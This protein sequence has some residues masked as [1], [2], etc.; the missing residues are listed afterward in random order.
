[1]TLDARAPVLLLGGT[2]WVGTQTTKL[3]RQL[4]PTLPIAIA[5]R[6]R[7]KAEALAA[8]WAHTVAV[9]ADVGQ[10]GLGLGPQASYSAVVA[11]LKENTLHP[12]RFAQAHGLPYISMADGAFEIGPAVARHIHRPGS[13]PMM[14]ASHWAAGM[15]TLP[16]LHH[17]SEFRSIESIRAAVIMDPNDPIG[18]MAQVDVQQ[19]MQ[20][21]PRPL[22]LDNGVWR[23]ID[24]RIASRRLKN[25][26][27]NE[28]QVF[29]M[30]V[31][32]T[33]SLAAA[34]DARSVRLDFGT[35]PTSGDGA[36]GACPHELVLE[37][38]GVA[39]DGRPGALRVDISTPL[40][41]TGLTAL[42]V[43]LSIERLL[44][45]AGGEPAAPGLYFPENLIHPAHAMARLADFGAQVWRSTPI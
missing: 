16:I 17:A 4:H 3:L 13:A 9:Q 15:T 38:E 28:V 8:Q 14:L 23:W 5:G 39:K 35:A 12:L 2:G 33:I 40:G 19:V 11:L 41:V 44:G 42:G 43:V 27:G 20:N 7:A 25:R 1:M 26:A 32:D 36:E 37:I 29:A 18:P 31:L 34:T 21:S 45:L 10:V 22:V 6:D 24:E 30:S